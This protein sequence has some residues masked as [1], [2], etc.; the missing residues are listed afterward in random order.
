MSKKLKKMREYDES[1]RLKHTQFDHTEWKL[2]GERLFKWE[3]S[4]SYAKIIYAQM[5]FCSSQ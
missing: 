4:V 1:A 3:T 2:P 5:F